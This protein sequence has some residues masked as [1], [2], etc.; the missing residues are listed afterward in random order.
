M[1]KDHMCVSL[2]PLFNHLDETDQRVIH[3]LVTHHIKE[4]GELIFTPTSAD[5]LVIVARGSLKVYQLSANGKEQVLRVIEPGGYEGEKQLFGVRNEL[6]FGEALEKTEVC[7][8]KQRDFT[9]LLLDYPQLSLKLLEVSTAAELGEMIVAVG[10]AQNLA[11]IRA[12][13]TDG[14]QKGH[15][16]MQSRSLA[17]TAGATEK[18]IAQVSRQLRRADQMNLATAETIIKQLRQA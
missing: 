6:L 1:A 5:Q 10:L 4:K 15:M 7:V 9:Q 3:M 11:A 2:V 18:E 13:V 8:L 14:I 16:A 17:I 12:L